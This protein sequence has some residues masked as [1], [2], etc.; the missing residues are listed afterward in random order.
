MFPFGQQLQ[1]MALD[2]CTKFFLRFHSIMRMKQ[3]NSALPSY[4]SSK[5]L[6]A[7]LQP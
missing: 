5:G 1:N 3:K 4:P 2:V 6:L 7:T